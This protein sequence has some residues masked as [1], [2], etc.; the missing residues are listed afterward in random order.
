MCRATSA[1]RLA[2]RQARLMDQPLGPR[3][4]AQPHGH[5]LC[6]QRR[7]SAPRLNQLDVAALQ[8]KVTEP[9]SRFQLQR[10]PC[11]SL[12]AAYASPASVSSTTA[13][14]TFVSSMCR[15]T[16]STTP[17][18][19]VI[20]TR[21]NAS[22]A[23]RQARRQAQRM[24]PPPEDQQ[25]GPQLA[26]RLI[27]QPLARQ[28]WLRPRSSAPRFH[29]PDVAGPSRMV[30]VCSSRSTP[31]ASHCASTSA[32]FARRASESSTT[33]RRTCVSST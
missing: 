20:A 22:N 7:S 15:Q 25:T 31:Q 12:S 26:R 30:T 14:P 3:Q 10:L 19:A 21:S 6:R 28:L 17:R 1:N 2:Q 33:S 9:S 32:L 5:Q 8:Q 13:T 23:S 11:A 27:D 18:P 29:P 16:R 4:T 24:A